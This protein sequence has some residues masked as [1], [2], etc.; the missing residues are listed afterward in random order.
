MEKTN[1]YLWW[2]RIYSEFTNK[3]DELH[4]S[5]I[6]WDGEADAFFPNWDQDLYEL[7]IHHAAIEESQTPAWTYKFFVKK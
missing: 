4:L 6:D 2:R 5:Y 7:R 3:A 1:L